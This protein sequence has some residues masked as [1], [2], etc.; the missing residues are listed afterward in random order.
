M[1]LNLPG[2]SV[3]EILQARILEWVAMPTSRGIFV[4]QESNPFLLCLLHWQAGSLPLVPPGKPKCPLMQVKLC[5]CVCV[6]VYVYV[7]SNIYRIYIIIY[8]LNYI[9]QNSDYQSWKI[10]ADFLPSYFDPWAPGK[11]VCHSEPSTCTLGFSCCLH[12]AFAFWSAQ[13]LISVI[14]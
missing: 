14:P 6:C 12:V 7:Q 8:I 4:N 2:S 10:Q 1:D 5:V 11:G 13:D 9:K 3:H